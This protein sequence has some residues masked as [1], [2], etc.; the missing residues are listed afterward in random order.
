MEITV[1]ELL[2][3]L[4][5]Q[6]DPLSDTAL[7][8]AQVL[9]AHHLEKPRAWL[10]A[11]PEALLND[12][13]YQ[14]VLRS[15]QRLRDGEPLPYLLGHWEFY[16]LDFLITPDVLIPRPETE[17]LVERAIGWLRCHPHK[18]RVVEVGTG[19]GCIGIAIA[20]HIPDVHIL[21]A[22]RSP[23]ALHVARLNLQKHG[24][25]NRVKVKHSDLLTQI[26]GSFDLICANLPYIPTQTLE[27]LPV[28]KREPR[29]ALDG[30]ATGITLIE[31]LLNQAKGRLHPG[32]LILLEFD[33]VQVENLI[34]IARQCYPGSNVH[35][36]QDLA[37]RDRC[38]EFEL[39]YAIL[40]LCRRQAWLN[41]QATGEYRAESL[42]L[43]GFIH[44]SLPEQ[45]TD[46]ANRY[47]QG[48]PDLVVLQVDPHKLTSEIRWEKSD[49]AYY[50][51]VYGPINP[52]AVDRVTNIQLNSDGTF[53][54]FPEE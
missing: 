3:Q 23:Q 39:P 9:V 53:R 50:P 33:P 34:Q 8:D 25:V 43:E 44:C 24:L 4:K 40:H 49:Q 45:I 18:R 7:L 26:P 22:D 28:A 35:I 13:Q 19:S 12:A 41:S 27:K 48:V 38:L 5:E 16:G 51:H 42:E 6:L 31:R 32:G 52:E 14:R 37:G 10:L 11:H 17:L 46:V 2:K 21:M 1:H 30:G 47:Y 54:N 20:R 15:A 29:S 36:V